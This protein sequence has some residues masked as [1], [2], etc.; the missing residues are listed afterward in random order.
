MHQPIY[1]WKFYQ[2]IQLACHGRVAKST[3]VLSV[4]KHSAGSSPGRVI[5]VH[6]VDFITTELANRYL[7]V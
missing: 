1:A 5:S 7:A 6:F 3:R 2:E 4:V